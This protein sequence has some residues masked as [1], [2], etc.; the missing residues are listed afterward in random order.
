M[1][2]ARQN[3]GRRVRPWVRRCLSDRSVYTLLVLLVCVVFHTGEP[4]LAAFRLLWAGLLELVHKVLDVL[5]VSDPL[6]RAPVA[7][8]D[9]LFEEHTSVLHGVAAFEPA[10]HTEI[11]RGR[12]K[13]L[14]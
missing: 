14:V 9:N 5:C 2:A 8:D 10:L 1:Y 6:N 12:I 13:E 3:Q 4:L 11:T 7:R